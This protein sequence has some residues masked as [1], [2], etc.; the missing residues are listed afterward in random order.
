MVAQQVQ[1]DDVLLFNDAWGQIPFDYYFWRLY[2]GPLAEHG[3][4]VDLFDRGVL[5]PRMTEG[6]LWRV[7]A[8][9]A[10]RERVWLVYSHDWYT[11]PQG[12][13][14]GALEE[15]L[16]VLDGW[17]FYGLRVLLYGCGEGCGTE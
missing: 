15:K 5:E 17:D 11:D 14:P 9:I 16:S 8:L 3:L 12:L 13:V 4:P 6:D 1:P 10:G 7:W 2:N